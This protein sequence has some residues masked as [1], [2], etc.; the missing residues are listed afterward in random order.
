ME[1]SEERLTSVDQTLQD[2]LRDNVKDCDVFK[3]YEMEFEG[4][5]VI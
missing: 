2:Y 4:E 5:G 3:V 1:K